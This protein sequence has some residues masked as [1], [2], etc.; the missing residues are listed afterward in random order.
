MSNAFSD[1]SAT[2]EL[3]K[4]TLDAVGDPVFVKDRERRFLLLNDACCQLLGVTPGSSVGRTEREL[5]PH[6][7]VNLSSD[8][9]EMVFETGEDQVGEQTLIDSEGRM[10]IVSIR[11][12]LFKNGAGE[13][14]LVGVLHD[15]TERKQAVRLL[16]HQALHDRLT[17]LGNRVLF[18]RYLRKGTD[19]ARRHGRG[20]TVICFDPDRF[21]V[22]NETLGH[23]AGDRLLVAIARRLQSVLRPRDQVARLSGDK[24]A[25]LVE[26]C[27]GPQDAMRVADRVREAFRQPFHVGSTQAYVSLSIGIAWSPGA[28]ASEDLLRFADV[29]LR[30]A[31]RKG[32]SS[33]V[34]DAGID[35]AATERF[36]AQ[37]ELQRA[38]QQGELVLYYQPLVEMESGRVSGAE[39]L[40]RWMH[41]TRGLVPPDEFIPL[42]EETGL[43][44]PLGDWVLQEACRQK[45]L[46]K[47]RLGLGSDFTMSVNVSAKQLRDPGLAARTLEILGQT[48]LRADELV[49][50]L[51]ENV[52]LEETARAHELRDVGVR[53]AIDDFGTGYA[54][55]GYL[56]DLPVS[57][58]KIARPF[59]SK[60]GRDVVDTSLV[61]MIL[62]LVQDLGL[63]S[64][65]EGVEDPKQAKLLRQLRCNFA[66]GFLFARPMP[67]AE[68][69]RFVARN[70]FARRPAPRAR[71][72]SP[73][74]ELVL[75]S[76]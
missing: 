30:R 27:E 38:L 65:A 43:I 62:T 44:V 32:G 50:E 72:Y 64:V 74:N 13:P 5:D 25:C 14:F 70:N 61:N 19:A 10:R 28:E 71:A 21:N 26:S 3:L 60:L 15:V 40:V 9:D 12:T 22:I 57:M 24:F 31:K 37:N 36:H 48:G 34:F 29:A 58:L 17:G 33:E 39:A 67:A 2:T 1:P 46:W 51:T 54:S 49:F 69:E 8:N 18:E 45:V 53:L 68:F 55:L 11:K 47:R 23:Q 7:P 76:A 56:R 59:I 75:Q 66:Q 41:P 16:L 52:L 6:S 35:T 73:A 20:L 42:A 63:V 4:A